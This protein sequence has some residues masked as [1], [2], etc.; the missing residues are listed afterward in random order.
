MSKIFEYIYLGLAIACLIFMLVRYDSLF[1]D[2]IIYILIFMGV[3]SFLFA[4]RRTSR[5]RGE[6]LYAEQA[7]NDF[8]EES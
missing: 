1:P 3:F 6:K 5:I 2:K 7:K 8:E 4:F